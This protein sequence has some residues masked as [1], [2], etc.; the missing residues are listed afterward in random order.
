MHKIIFLKKSLSILVILLFF[1]LAVSP[2]LSIDIHTISDSKEEVEISVNIYGF[3]KIDTHGVTLSVKDAEKI[4]VLFN[5]IKNKLDRATIREET[6]AIFNDAIVELNNLGLLP[7]NM[8]VGEVSKLVTGE[9]QNIKLMKFLND[10]YYSIG[11]GST[12]NRKASKVI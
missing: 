1:G 8:D 5:E 12:R 6:V 9:Y 7:E 2:S 11:K 10:F 3:D 4:D